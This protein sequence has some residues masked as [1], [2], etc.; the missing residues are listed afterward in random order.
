MSS[1]RRLI[2]IGAI[3]VLLLA[4]AAVV[5]R[6]ASSGP[7][8]RLAA[9]VALAPETTGRLTWTDW[10]GVRRELDAD[11][12][13]SS[14]G[15]Q[16]QRFLDRAWDADLTS[17]S[18][19]VESS[20]TMHDRYGISPA[21][22]EWELLA[23]GEVGQVIVMGLPASLDLDQLRKTLESLGY[24][25][26]GERGGTWEGSA[27][28][29]LDL[30]SLTNELAN[31]RVDEEHRVLIASDRASYLDSWRETGRGDDRGDGIAEVVAGF[32]DDEQQALSAFVYSGDYVCGELAM[33]QADTS[34]QD[35]AAQLIAEA[36]KVH[37]M[38]GF[39]LAG[40]AD[41]RARVAMAFET[42]DAA[43]TDAD[44]RAVL[45]VGPAPGQGGSFADRFKLGEVTA[46]GSLVTMSL[47]RRSG[48]FVLSDLSAGPVLFATC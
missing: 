41:R 4:T 37:P 30:G 2:V 16:V 19:L 45:A 48:A 6:W 42:E 21:N 34:A 3:L 23:Q 27:E 18:A 46:A 38:R 28:L 26:P 9:A 35:E 17:A 29:L 13:A 36:G 43:R 8:S 24:Q 33:S 14:S 39:A 1:K 40:L 44:T 12:T 5:V 25:K 20:P 15:G 32:D 11:L 10:S 47:T 22:L 7:D 31:L